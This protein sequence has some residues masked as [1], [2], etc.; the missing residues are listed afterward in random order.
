AAVAMPIIRRAAIRR[1]LD[2]IVRIGAPLPDTLEIRRIDRSARMIRIGLIGEGRG[3]EDDGRER[4]L[5][6]RQYI[7]RQPVLTGIAGEMQ[8]V[9]TT[10]H[11]VG[12]GPG[13]IRLP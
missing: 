1:I 8:R 11:V 13:K 5:P 9:R 2:W 10:R 7:Q 12:Y 6:L 3:Q 4:P